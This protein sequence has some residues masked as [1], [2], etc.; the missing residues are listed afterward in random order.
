VSFSVF[1]DWNFA[2]GTPE[3]VAQELMGDEKGR[4]Q[5]VLTR[6]AN[7]MKLRGAFASISVWLFPA[8]VR[9]VAMLS[10]KISFRSLTEVSFEFRVARARAARQTISGDGYA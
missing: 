3:S 8:P 5:E 7:R 1:R 6:N 10:E 9:E 2:N 4:S